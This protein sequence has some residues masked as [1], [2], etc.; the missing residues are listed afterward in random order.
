MF[1]TDELN[2]LDDESFICHESEQGWGV[3]RDRINNPV[4]LLTKTNKMKMDP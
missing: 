1:G 2:D 4:W 3:R